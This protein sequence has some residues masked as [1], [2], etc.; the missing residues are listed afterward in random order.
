MRTHASSPGGGGTVTGFIASNGTTTTSA[1]IPFAQGISVATTKPAY[2][3]GTTDGNA[4][5]KVVDSATTFKIQGLAGATDGIDTHVIG[6]TA[7]NIGGTGRGGMVYLYGGDPDAGGDLLG[8]HGFTVIGHTITGFNGANNIGLSLAS[9][10]QYNDLAVE[11]SF[12]AASIAIF[13]GGIGTGGKLNMT[14][15]SVLGTGQT[16]QIIGL[17][18][19]NSGGTDVGVDHTFQAGWATSS[20]TNK[21]GGD[22][23]VAGGVPTGNGTSRTL[24][25]AY[26]GGTSGTS[27]GSPTTCV[28]VTVTGVVFNVQAGFQSQSITSSSS[29]IAWDANAA[30]N[31]KHTLTENTTLDN[32]T[33]TLEGMVYVVTFT[34]HASSPKTLSFGTMYKF[35]GGAIPALTAANSAVDKLVCQKDGSNL[36]CVMINNIS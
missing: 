8:N 10:N 23:I 11:G 17:D 36:S 6:G 3:G 20:S 13:A 35:P 32:P 18:R 29:H 14:G 24:L 22:A 15:Y 21:N 26:G 34:Q 19:K 31:A 28:T 12:Y 16:A 7:P 25:K 2:F 4:H 5:G 30:Q 33:N 27:D 1:S 9:G